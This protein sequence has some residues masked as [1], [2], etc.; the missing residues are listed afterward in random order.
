MPEGDNFI[1]TQGPRAARWL[2]YTHTTEP[3]FDWYEQNMQLMLRKFCV[4]LNLTKLCR[5]R[6]RKRPSHWDFSYCTPDKESTSRTGSWNVTLDR[7]VMK[8]GTDKERKK[9]IVSFCGRDQK[10][11]L[12]ALRLFILHPW[13]RVNLKDWIVKCY[14]GSRRNEMRDRQ[15]KKERKS[16]LL[17]SRPSIRLSHFKRRRNGVD[18]WPKANIALWKLRFQNNVHGQK[19]QF[20]LP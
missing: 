18:M 12:P 1:L 6:T 13:Q 3:R 14:F 5:E 9:E 7:G 8:C 2:H 19:Y 4:P 11:T 15:G 10:K 16:F 20:I 17:W